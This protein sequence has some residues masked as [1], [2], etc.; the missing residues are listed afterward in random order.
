LVVEQDITHATL[1]ELEHY[2]S[3]GTRAEFHDL[4][5][6][7]MHCS[8]PVPRKFLMALARKLLEDAHFTDGLSKGERETWAEFADAMIANL[9]EK[10]SQSDRELLQV[11][12]AGEKDY[13]ARFGY[14]SG[15]IYEVLAPHQVFS[16]H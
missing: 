11:A 10:A 3:A 1:D 14:L 16:D 4:L 5:E 12:W 6:K 7:T 13:A 9:M 2:L 8:G 15:A